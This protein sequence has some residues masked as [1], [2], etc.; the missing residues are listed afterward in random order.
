[1][2]GGR[3]RALCTLCPLRR[4]ALQ[5]RDDG[6]EGGG[7][8]VGVHAHAKQGLGL[9][10]AQFKIGGGLGIGTSADGV[11]VLVNHANA[12]ARGRLHRLDEGVY[13]AIALPVHVNQRPAPAQLA[14]QAHRSIGLRLKH[15]V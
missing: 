4:G 14:A 6:F 13:R 2:S 5:A 7:N 12:V 15:A 3:N 1:M 11:L 10:H 9:V 8:D